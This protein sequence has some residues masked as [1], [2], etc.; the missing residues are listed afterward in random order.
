[1]QQVPSLHHEQLL[2]FQMLSE[3]YEHNMTENSPCWNN[4]NVVNQMQQYPE[5][6]K[7]HKINIV[8]QDLDDD[9]IYCK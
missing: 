7:S 8:R 5:I 9:D 2:T 6:D 4:T 3:T 1:M